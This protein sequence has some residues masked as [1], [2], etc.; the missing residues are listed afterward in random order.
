MTAHIG[1]PTLRLVRWRIG[2]WNL[3][4]IPTGSYRVIDTLPP[5]TTQH[6]DRT[7]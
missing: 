5:R 3:E 2:E 7:P 6:D 1:F 4:G